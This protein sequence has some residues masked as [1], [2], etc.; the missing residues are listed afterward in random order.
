MLFM[1]LHLRQK[2]L[3]ASSFG[4]LQ[5]EE[6]RLR[7]ILV[8]TYVFVHHR[9]PCRKHPPILDP[10]S[11]VF[12][13]VPLAPHAHDSRKCTSDTHFPSLPGVST[14]MSSVIAPSICLKHTAFGIPSLR[15]GQS[16]LPERVLPSGAAAMSSA[17][18]RAHALP[19]QLYIF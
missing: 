10:F 2:D 4:P 14:C 13:P 16:S 11:S 17:N 3:S 8:P 5:Q 6:R 19:S 1:S 9:D 7:T 15:R 18:Q 12:P